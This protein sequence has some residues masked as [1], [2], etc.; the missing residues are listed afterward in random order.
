MSIQ[1]KKYF[2]TT[3]LGMPIIQK[4]IKSSFPYLNSLLGLVFIISLLRFAYP[5][6]FYYSVDKTCMRIFTFQMEKLVSICSHLLYYPSKIHFSI[7]NIA[8]TLSHASI[9]S[10][11][12]I[13]TSRLVPC[14]HLKTCHMQEP[15]ALPRASIVSLALMQALQT[16]SY[17]R[18]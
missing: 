15:Q 13:S 8:Q 11:S 6:C 14:K 12:L 17:A 9:I 4:F 1:P 5:T 18:P 3:N 7:F 10:L 16:L 2:R